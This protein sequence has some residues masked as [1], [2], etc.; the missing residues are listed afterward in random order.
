MIRKII[1]SD[2]KE[3]LRI[4]SQIWEGE[5]YIS[6]VFDEWTKSEDS[7]FA[8][9]WENDKLIGFGRMRY[10]TST[11]IWLEALRK[12]PQT[13]IRGVGNK[14]ALYFMDQ[15]K[16]EKI[17]SIRFSTYFDNITSI[18]LNEK[19]GFKKILT[20]SLKE[21]ELSDVNVKQQSSKLF[22]NIEFNKIEKYIRNTTYLKGSNN[23]IAIGWVVQSYSKKLIK[24]IHEKQHYAVYLE[25]KKINGVVL[26]SKDVYKKILW[27]N[28][29][30]AEREP[31]FNELI[32]FVM[33]VAKQNNCNKIQ[34]LVPNDTNL[35]N[36]VNKI[37][38]KSWEQND[39]LLLFEMPRNLIKHI[40]SV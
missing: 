18:K 38:F 32:N 5:D 8:G 40:T 12:D 4:S 28:A 3:V 7:I 2:K 1:Y 17:D 25:N 10:L 15:L 26:Y 30:E 11:D 19:L 27:I 9:Y 24:T 13:K 37:G 14:I 35:M 22:S 23:F 33:N 6:E 16:W 31:V 20:L 29:I 36:Q 39:D 34:L 21:L